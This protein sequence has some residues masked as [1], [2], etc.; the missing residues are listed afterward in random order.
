MLSLP[1]L[2]HVSHLTRYPAP[3]FSLLPPLVLQWKQSSLPH[4]SCFNGSDFA[5]CLFAFP[6]LVCMTTLIPVTVSKL[7]HT[8]FI[9][10]VIVPATGS[11]I[12]GADNCF[13]LYHF[14]ASFSSHLPS[15]SYALF[16]SKFSVGVPAS[17]HYPHLCTYCLISHTLSLLPCAV[18]C[19][20]N[21]FV[22]TY[23]MGPELHYTSATLPIHPPGMVP[24]PPDPFF[25]QYRYCHLPT[26]GR[27]IW[28]HH[29]CCTWLLTKSVY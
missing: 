22:L 9:S 25:Y 4:F 27:L 15:Q 6:A 1:S 7:L 18:L 8:C 24:Q 19:P 16:L 11:T 3:F 21:H 26:V 13:F 17:P 5:S 29:S 28:Y 2:W 14:C 10:V 23:A 20:G 12:R